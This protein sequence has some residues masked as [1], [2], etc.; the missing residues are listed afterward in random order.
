MGLSENLFKFALTDEWQ[1]FAV[2]ALAAFFIPALA[3]EMV[4][5][6]WLGGRTGW[7]RGGLAVTAFVVWHPAQVWLGL[8]MAQDLFLEPAFL[9]ITALLGL[10]CTLAYR[11]SASIWPPVLIHWVT[12][13]LWKGLTAPVTG[14]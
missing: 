7:I 14:L 6:V 11:L 10:T 3:E 5:R 9:A 1:A 8:P 2:V 12:V 13:V 4:F